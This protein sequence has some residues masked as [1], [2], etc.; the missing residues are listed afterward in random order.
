MCQRENH[1]KRNNSK[2]TVVA[3]TIEVT[4]LSGLH[5]NKVFFIKLDSYSENEEFSC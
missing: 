5:G 2:I 1:L 3:P 4:I